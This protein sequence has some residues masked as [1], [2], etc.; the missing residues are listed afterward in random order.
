MNGMSLMVDL[1]CYSQQRFSFLTLRDLHNLV[2]HGYL[3]VN[4]TR[5][6][7]CKVGLFKTL[8][9]FTSPPDPSFCLQILSLVLLSSLPSEKLEWKLSCGQCFISYVKGL[10]LDCYFCAETNNEVKCRNF[11]V[12]VMQS[13]YKEH[14]ALSPRLILLAFKGGHPSKPFW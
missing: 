3:C 5:K 10:L 8:H 12:S 9:L 11:D 1:R 14:A 6:T 2:I 7:I 13:H 4:I